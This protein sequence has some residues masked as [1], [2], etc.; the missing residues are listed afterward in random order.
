MLRIFVNF[1]QGAF[2]GQFKVYPF[3]QLN[4]IELNVYCFC[5]NTI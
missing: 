5:Y 4:V 2:L 1:L 3:G